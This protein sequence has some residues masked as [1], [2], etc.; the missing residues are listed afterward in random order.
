MLITV[1][2]LPKLVQSKFLALVRTFSKGN[3]A[4]V[5]ALKT[6]FE[7]HNLCETQK[8]ALEEGM[9]CLFRDFMIRC[10]DFPKDYQSEDLFLATR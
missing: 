5:A 7:K 1:F 10:K 9:F 6:L 4:L 3:A 8:I 2:K